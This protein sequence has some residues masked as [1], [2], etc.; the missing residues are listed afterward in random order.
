MTTSERPDKKCQKVIFGK[1][2]IIKKFR[3]LEF[4]RTVYIYGSVI[5][6]TNKISNVTCGCKFSISAKFLICLPYDTIEIVVS[7][8]CLNWTLFEIRPIFCQFYYFLHTL[9]NNSQ[10]VMFYTKDRLF[11]EIQTAFPYKWISMNCF[12]VLNDVVKFFWLS[13]VWNRNLD[14]KKIWISLLNKY[15]SL[16]G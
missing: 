13:N 10:N 14:M 12:Y 11:I 15:L 3:N 16:K 8:C 5:Q 6:S 1:N 7:S 2:S 9:L 4:Q